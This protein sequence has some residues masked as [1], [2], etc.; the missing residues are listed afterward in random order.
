MSNENLTPILCGHCC[1]PL[2][3]NDETLCTAVDDVVCKD[4]VRKYDS[5]HNCSD[6][7]LVEDLNRSES[8]DLYCQDCYDKLDCCDRCECR[9]E[10]LSLTS[11]YTRGGE[12][13]WCDGCVE[14]NSFYCDSCNE[15]ISDNHSEQYQVRGIGRVC[16]G[17]FSDAN[18]F[19]CEECGNYFHEDDDGG[20][21]MC[22][23]CVNR[24]GGSYINSYSYKPIPIFLLG[25]NQVEK[26]DNLY[27]GIELEVEKTESNIELRDM[28]KSIEQKDV[29]YLKQDGSLSNGFEIVTH[30]MTY[31]Y[32]QENK[33]KIFLEPLN[34][35]LK[36]GY[37]S[38]DSTTCGI[39][40]HISK[41]AFGTWQLYRFLTFFVENKD[42][43][44]QISQRKVEQLDRWASIESETSNDL[45]Y[46]AKKKDGNYKRYVAVNLQNHHTV[47]IRIFRGTLNFQ[48]FIKNVEFC[49][50][51]FNFTKD[52][53]DITLTK[54]KQY[55][56]DSHH[57]P[58]LKKFIKI[59]NL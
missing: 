34:K 56:D 40:I 27:F 9:D 43:I 21:D 59:K 5:C 1:E 18:C 46:K 8:E 33:E 25:K 26:K 55:I 39:H 30:P 45:I 24:S 49:H 42:F 6:I 38:Y 23:Y 53:K 10:D 3:E 19:E 47:E 12:E 15:T 54:F 13:C 51:L 4:C 52:S 22:R 11:V 29:Y 57:Y 58:T 41:K 37:R 32:I 31:Q 36:G 44:T 17:C 28:A 2:D 35:L 16:Q 7:I 48:S 14:N 50:A 20:E